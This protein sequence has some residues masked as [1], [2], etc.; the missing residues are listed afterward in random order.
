MIDAI[1]VEWRRHHDIDG[2]L[3]VK[4][5]ERTDHLGVVGGKVSL[6][7]LERLAI[8]SAEHNNDNV[9]LKIAGLFI[10][11]LDP[12]G[13]VTLF[14]CG[15]TTDAKVGNFVIARAVAV[16]EHILELDWVRVL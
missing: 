15:S 2:W 14:E 6:V 10:F 9:R 7:P 11:G 16:C 3:A 13:M 4:V 12:V 5:E 1:L 8:I